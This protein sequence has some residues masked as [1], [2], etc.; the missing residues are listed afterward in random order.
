[1]IALRDMQG[2]QCGLSAPAGLGERGGAAS[3]FLVIVGIRTSIFRTDDGVI[4]AV[5]L[6][7]SWRWRLVISIVHVV[8]FQPA[9]TAPP[10]EFR[11]QDND[12]A[13]YLDGLVDYACLPGT[14]PTLSAM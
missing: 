4:D 11:C 12:A 3:P 8:G 14:S 13:S 1:M 6:Y 9:T 2:N 5:M 7:R 10:T